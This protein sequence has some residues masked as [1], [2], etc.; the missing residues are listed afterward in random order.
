[1]TGSEILSRFKPLGNESQKKKTKLVSKTNPPKPTTTTE[2]SPPVPSTFSLHFLSLAWFKKHI[3]MHFQKF[4]DERD[5]Q[6]LSLSYLRQ[7]T[8]DWSQILGTVFTIS[9]FI[10]YTWLFGLVE[11]TAVH[12][13]VNTIYAYGGGSHY[14]SLFSNIMSI[15]SILTLLLIVVSYQISI[16][17]VFSY[18]ISMSLVSLFAGLDSA[19]SESQDRRFYALCAVILNL[20]RDV[21]VVDVVDEHDVVDEAKGFGGGSGGCDSVARQYTLA[22]VYGGPKLGTVLGSGDLTSESTESV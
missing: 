9:Q 4:P 2:T 5:E 19:V 10:G 14:R 8:P 17:S 11:D 16:K 6:A 21:D 15:T 3:E 1:M 22:N 13:L 20:E 7:I 18:C 12:L